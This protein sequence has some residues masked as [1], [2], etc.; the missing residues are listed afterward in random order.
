MGSILPCHSAINI[1]YTHTRTHTPG[2]ISLIGKH[3]IKQIHL[4]GY[5]GQIDSQR[6]DSGSMFLLASQT[7]PVALC[8]LCVC[9]SVCPGSI[10]LL[11]Q[12]SACSRHINIKTAAARIR[13]RTGSSGA[14]RVH[15]WTRLTREA[16]GRAPPLGSI[17]KDK[18]LCFQ[19]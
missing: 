4:N 17:D 8:V 6:G 15:P 9:L 16:P 11:D 19:T 5:W 13:G 12:L 10:C 18:C 14:G 7:H 3:Q 1:S 2:G